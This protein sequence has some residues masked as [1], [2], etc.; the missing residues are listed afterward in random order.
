MSACLSYD[1]FQLYLEM[2]VVFHL[3]ICTATA[4]DST[5]GNENGLLG[6]FFF[7]LV[8]VMWKYYKKVGL[9]VIAEKLKTCS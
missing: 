1:P 7:F 5:V 6:G 8:M 2:S 3:S 9:C 4:N